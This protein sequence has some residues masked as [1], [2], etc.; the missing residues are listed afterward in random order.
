MRLRIPEK[1][2]KCPLCRSQ[3]TQLDGCEDDYG[4]VFPVVPTMFERYNFI[5]RLA[6]FAVVAVS[7]IAFGVNLMVPHESLWSIF[8]AIG[9][10]CGWIALLAALRRRNNI[11]RNIFN[12]ALLVSAFALIWDFITG[13]R[14]WSVDFV[15]PSLFAFS[16][17][18]IIATALI[19]KIPVERYLMYLLIN[20]VFAFVPVILV[21][22]GVVKVIYPSYIC[23]IIAAVVTAWLVILYTNKMISEVKRRFHV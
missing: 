18:A 21:A 11:Q 16:I 19:L 17:I 10:F 4:A 13:W 22:C 6:L 14:G 9:A 5:I 2:V 8:V 7:A 15:M 12:Q 1:E 20:C 3:T 23:T